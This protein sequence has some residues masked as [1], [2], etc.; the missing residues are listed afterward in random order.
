MVESFGSR[1]ATLSE[2][3]HFPNG[4]LTRSRRLYDRVRASLPGFTGSNAAYG[5]ISTPDT[6]RARAR[7]ACVSAGRVFDRMIHLMTFNTRYLY[8]RIYGRS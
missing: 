7:G 2:V 3:Y 5:A 1:D 8:C 4:R 6:R